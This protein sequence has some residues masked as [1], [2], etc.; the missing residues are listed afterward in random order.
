[1]LAR[2]F[3]V[4]QLVV[5]TNLAESLRDLDLSAKLQLPE[6]LVRSFQ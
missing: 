6:S 2:S 1:M 3:K 5:K 4:G